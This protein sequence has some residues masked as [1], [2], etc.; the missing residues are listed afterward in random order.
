[1]GD[2]DDVEALEGFR[3]PCPGLSIGGGYDDVPYPEFFGRFL[4]QTKDRLGVFLSR[5]SH[6]GDSLLNGNHPNLPEAKVAYSFSKA[7]LPSC[8]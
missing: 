1:M 5:P 4:D 6:I 2:H 7:L 8:S 3:A